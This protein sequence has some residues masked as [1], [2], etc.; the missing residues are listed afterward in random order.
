MA[1]TTNTTVP[2]MDAFEAFSNQT[3]ALADAEANRASTSGNNNQV[4]YEEQKWV[5]L[6]QGKYHIMRIVGN[7]PESMTPGFKAADT[8]AHEIYYSEIKADDGKKFQLRLPVRG[9]LP[10]KDHLMW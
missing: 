9:D 6:D 4:T 2:S 7:P 1:E 10:E 8:D 5:G 3:Q